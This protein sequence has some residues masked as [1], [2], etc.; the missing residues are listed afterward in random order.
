MNIVIIGLTITSS[1]GNGHATTYRSLIKGL[2]KREHQVLF[3]EHDKP[4]YAGNRDMPDPT[5]CK[6]RLYASLEELKQQYVQQVREA[7]L[8]IVGSYTVQG[9]EV[10]Q[11]VQQI[12][13]GTKAFYDIDTPVTLAKLQRGDYE[14]LTPELI[15]GYDLYL[16]FTGGTALE[17]LEKQYNSPAARPLYCLSDPDLY[18]PQQGTERIFDLGYM[19]TYSPDRQPP[20]RKLMLEAAHQWPE[21]RFLV[22]GPQFPQDIEWPQNVQ[23]KD[24]LPPAEHRHF[25]NSQRFTLNITR[26]DMVRLGYSPS[27]RLFEAAMC[28]TPIISDWWEGLD[29]FF[30]PGEEILISNS[31]ADTL[32]FLKKTTAEERAAMGERARQKALQKHSPEQRAKELEIYVQAFQKAGSTI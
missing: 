10:G 7:D 31:P 8:V 29:E 30:T 22:V 9:V 21:G 19:G 3:L 16:S 14:Y 1:W 5:F 23:R 4:W 6:T 28:G 11:W 12:A 17:I 24:H 20:L 26:A 2:Q 15:P 25:Y 13:E 32:Q 27:V 18:F